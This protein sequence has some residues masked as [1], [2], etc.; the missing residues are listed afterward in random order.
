MGLAQVTCGYP[1][2]GGYRFR[3]SFGAAAVGLNHGGTHDRVVSVVAV[4]DVVAAGGLVHRD[5]DM[6]VVA[7]VPV[8]TAAVHVVTTR[9]APNLREKTR[10]QKG[11]S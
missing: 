11:L 1:V 4:Y 2:E 5:D 6:V 3:R 8:V 9:G 10:E 7:A